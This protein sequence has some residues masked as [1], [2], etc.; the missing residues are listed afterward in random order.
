MS[1]AQDRAYNVTLCWL[2][3][4]SVFID[5]PGHKSEDEKNPVP[6]LHVPS[7]RHQ[8]NHGCNLSNRWLETDI[9]PCCWGLLYSV[10][11]KPSHH[12]VHASRKSN[13]TLTP[14]RTSQTNYSLNPRWR[15]PLPLPGAGR[16]EDHGVRAAYGQPTRS[17]KM[18][19]SIV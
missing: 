19:H 1:Y 16:T 5:A 10:S 6:L 13:T 18:K 9:Y 4:D 7:A 3:S 8:K 11:E 14:S 15:S 12:S 17:K 2:V